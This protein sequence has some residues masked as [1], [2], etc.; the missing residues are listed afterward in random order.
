MTCRQIDTYVLVSKTNTFTSRDTPL[1]GTGYAKYIPDSTYTVPFNGMSQ[2]LN[3]NNKWWHTSRPKTGMLI[4]NLLFK[5]HFTIYQFV[6][7]CARETSLGTPR[8]AWHHTGSQK[9]RLTPEH[10]MLFGTSMTPPQLPVYCSR[11]L[12]HVLHCL[13]NDMYGKQLREY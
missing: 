5:L 13:I 10:L 1:N 11:K 12:A 3:I 2:T 8:H 4:D 9:R 7:Q 6:I